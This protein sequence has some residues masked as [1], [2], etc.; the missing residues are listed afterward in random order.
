M[1]DDN[2]DL[3]EEE[4]QVLQSI[5][6]DCILEH[7]LN[8]VRFEVPVELGTPRNV[9]VIISS[10]RTASSSATS[11]LKLVHLPPILLNVQLPKGYPK[12]CPPT[13]QS[14]HATHSWLPCEAQLAQVLLGSWI[15]GEGALCNWVELI[16]SG[17]FIDLLQLVDESGVIRLEHIGPHPLLTQILLEH[18]AAATSNE[19]AQTSFSCSICF[20]SLKGA[21]C[22][23][24]SCSHVFCRSCLQDY[25]GSCIAEGSVERVGCADPVCVKEAR[26]ASEEEV[27]RVV[28]DKETIRW[29]WL[30]TKKE[31]EKDPTT[32]HCPIPTCQAPV[33]KL[34]S[35]ADASQSSGW[36]RLRTCSA[37]SF[38]FCSFCR[39]TWHGPI[40]ECPKSV[41]HS[42]VMEYLDLPE[43]SPER[44]ALERKFGKG[45]FLKLVKQYE[46]D[47]STKDWLSNSTTAC[48]GCHIHVEKS[49]GCN[50]MMCAKC[51]Q[52]F[53]Y[54]CGAKLIASDPYAHFSAAG[55]DCHGKLFDAEDDWQPI[56][57]FDLL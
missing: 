54:R 51:Q 30:K 20:D 48:P 18:D 52:H 24:L 39:H 23:Q 2:D 34:V 35:D 6:P 1:N 47:E 14:I 31:I 3:R 26:A 25:W 28:S 11:L 10:S 42:L 38:S 43:R 57:G 36:D 40:S 49:L 19:F 44:L 7:S 13:I 16:R 56:E 46:E 53:C 5:Y 17:D 27:R 41:T 45:V 33:P 22:I 55:S 4:L 8:Y 21:R 29:K 12:A 9:C 50:H 15:N 37:C 32:V